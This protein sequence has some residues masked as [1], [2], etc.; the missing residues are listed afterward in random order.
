MGR[1]VDVDQLVGAWEIADRLSV[2]RPQVVHEWR[3]RHDDF[4]EP[5]VELRQVLIWHWPDVEKWA[6]STGRLGTTWKRRRQ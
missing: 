6:E 4:P 2:A 3:R 5:V 1:R